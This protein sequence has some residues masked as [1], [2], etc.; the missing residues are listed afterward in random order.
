MRVSVADDPAGDFAES[1]LF[2]PEFFH[3][4]PDCRVPRTEGLGD[5]VGVVADGLIVQPVVGRD[6]VGQGFVKGWREGVVR[7]ALGGDGFDQGRQQVHMAADAQ[8]GEEVRRKV[9]V[10]HGKGRAV[11]FPDAAFPVGVQRASERNDLAGVVARDE[12]Q[13][14]GEALLYLFDKGGQGL[15]RV[16]VRFQVSQEI[17]AA[18]HVVRQFL[19][20]RCRV[21]A[22]L[23]NRDGVRAV[24]RRGVDEMEDRRIVIQVAH[25]LERRC[26]EEMVIDAEPGGRGV[27]RADVRAAVGFVE[28]HALGEQ[29][30]AGPGQA[31]AVPQGRSIAQLFQLPRQRGQGLAIPKRPFLVDFQVVVENARNEARNG[32]LGD[33]AGGKEVRDLD[34]MRI[35][36]EP[37]KRGGESPRIRR[38]CAPKSSGP[39]P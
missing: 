23:P 11:F 18:L 39:A 17:L 24:V 2:R 21:E 26:E 7:E 32:R 37:E 38:P 1:V 36:P 13:A 19:R 4:P 34:R 20:D 35:G 28:A 9:P 6:D 8:L 27:G 30:Q 12:D 25:L 33:Q 16:P 15:V 29:T 10:V 31:A 5:F 22:V 14:V 3:L